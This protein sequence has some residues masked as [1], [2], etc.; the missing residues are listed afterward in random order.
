MQMIR[1]SVFQ[2]ACRMSIYTYLDR[3]VTSLDRGGQFLIWSMR[4]WVAAH[5]EGICPGVRLGPA[6]AKWGMI[7]SLAP[8][9]MMMALINRHGLLTFSFGQLPCRHVHEHEALLISLIS[10]VQSQRPEHVNALAESLVENEA[11]GRFLDS[12]VKLAMGL[13]ENEMVPGAPC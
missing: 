5:H 7:G 9:N 3:P 12:V 6:F 8:F 4:S 11:I 2:G 13:S 1:N 10:G